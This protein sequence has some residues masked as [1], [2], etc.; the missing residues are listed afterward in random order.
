[1]AVFAAYYLIDWGM[2]LFRGMFDP[3]ALEIAALMLLG[4][5]LGGVGGAA[6]AAG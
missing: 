6:L 2:V 3:V 1:M 5:L 4:A